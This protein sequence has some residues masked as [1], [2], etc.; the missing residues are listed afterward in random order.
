MDIT[1]D[2]ARPPWEQRSAH[3][4]CCLAFH[5]AAAACC[6][7]C[8]AGFAQWGGW[9]GWQAQVWGDRGHTTAAGEWV[10]AM[11]AW[12]GEGRPVGGVE[13]GERLKCGVVVALPERLVSCSLWRWCSGKMF[14]GGGGCGWLGGQN[15][16]ASVTGA[17]VWWTACCS[18]SL[19]H[20]SPLPFDRC[21][22]SLS[23]P[24]LSHSW[25]SGATGARSPPL[26]RLPGVVWE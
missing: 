26:V 22:P 17:R 20:P 24:S 15:G 9:R 23:R 8:A 11:W 19:T 3:S 25:Q 7:C 5:S 16:C 13:Q 18:P 12:T 2:L 14:R 4:S 10:W 6:A 21:H 1:C